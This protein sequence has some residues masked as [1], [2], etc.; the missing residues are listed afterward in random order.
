VAFYEPGDALE[1]PRRVSKAL[2]A[3]YA[4]LRALAGGSGKRSHPT[5]PRRL[6]D[7][8]EPMGCDGSRTSAPAPSSWK[9]DSARL[10]EDAAPTVWL[11]AF[12]HRAHRTA[13]VVATRTGTQPSKS[14]CGICWHA[15]AETL[16][17]CDAAY[18]G[19]RVGPGAIP[20]PSVV[21]VPDVIA[22]PSLTLSKSS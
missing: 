22:G 12:V 5:W 21:P 4:S 9:E 18:M 8:F 16:I 6:V 11:T 2:D 3:S 1:D 7:G 15:L 13:L 19:L 14:I 20:C 10:Q 17:I